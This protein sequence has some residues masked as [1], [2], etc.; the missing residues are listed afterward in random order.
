ME[1]PM[2]WNRAQR[3]IDEALTEHDQNMQNGMCGASLITIIY[4]ALSTAGLL[5]QEASQRD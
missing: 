5:T 3:V 1:N 2:T 4:K